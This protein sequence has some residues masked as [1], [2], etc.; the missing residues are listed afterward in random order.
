MTV[1]WGT[2]AHP[3]LRRLFGFSTFASV[4]DLEIARLKN[5]RGLWE[6]RGVEAHGMVS[7]PI[8][9]VVAPT[10]SRGL[11]HR[12][13]REFCERVSTVPIETRRER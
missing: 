3:A 6:E 13:R 11:C 9:Q 10:R 5:S 1:V 12:L 7:Q 2:V 8:V 4:Q